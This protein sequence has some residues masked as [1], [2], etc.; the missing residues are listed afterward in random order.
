L[1]AVAA[2]ASTSK[3]AV[4]YH[5]GSRE[6]LL[7]QVAAVA[8]A[9]FRRLLDSAA[10]EGVS[11]RKLTLASVAKLFEAENRE[12][13]MCVH[14]LVGLG[15]R[16]PEVGRMILRSLDETAEGPAQSLARVHGEHAPDLARALIMSVQGHLE[17]FLCSGG[18]A[19]PKPYVESATRTALAIVQRATTS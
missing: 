7:R 6:Q 2:E 13:L 10:E 14:E 15:M 4:L 17:F 5:F 12:L 8:I 3:P 18:D 9:I 1:A 19:D 11:P 16:D